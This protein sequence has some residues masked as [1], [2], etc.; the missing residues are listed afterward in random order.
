MLTF[1]SRMQARPNRRWSST[2]M[3]STAIIFVLILPPATASLTPS[4]QCLWAICHLTCRRRNCESF[5][6]RVVPL[7]ASALCATSKH[8]LARALPLC[9]LKTRAPFL[10]LWRRRR[11]SS[12]IGNR[13]SPASAI[14]RRL[15]C[16]NCASFLEALFAWPS[17]RP[18]PMVSSSTLALPQATSASVAPT[19][20]ATALPRGLPAV[21][22]SAMQTARNGAIVIVL[23]RSR[24]RK[25]MPS[26]L[27]L[28]CHGTE[29][30]LPRRVFCPRLQPKLA[31]RV[32]IWRAPIA[33]RSVL[34]ARRARTSRPRRRL[35]VVVPQWPPKKRPKSPSLSR[36]PSR[37]ASRPRP[38]RNRQIQHA[39]DGTQKSTEQELGSYKRF[40]I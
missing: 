39:F 6:S 36:R 25:V 19:T 13:A 2:T 12:A 5:S 17:R 20:P 16:R 26:H 27:A 34:Q 29:A 32:W 21:A 18:R 8:P 14:R 3:S 11:Q 24:A 22:R 33:R 40:Q 9:F 1:C 38:A 23:K 7:R 15:R 37:R 10:W 4:A 31:R 30:L 28:Q 35:S